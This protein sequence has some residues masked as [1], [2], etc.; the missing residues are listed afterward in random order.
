MRK[1]WKIVK[2]LL[3]IY[4]IYIIF[5]IYTFYYSLKIIINFCASIFLRLFTLLMLACCNIPTFM[6]YKFCAF[7]PQPARCVFPLALS[8]YSHSHRTSAKY[9]IHINIPVNREKYIEFPVICFHHQPA[10]DSTLCCMML[11]PRCG[12][13]RYRS[14]RHEWV[15]QSV[16]HTW[17][18]FWW[19]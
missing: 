10:W 11:P 1:W 4:I 17:Y 14:F 8:S 12:R 3:Y 5:M 18:F 19:K 16:S 15:S 9:I 6:C 13:L 7:G 2:F